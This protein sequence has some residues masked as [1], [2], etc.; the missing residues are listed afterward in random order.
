LGKRQN[1]VLF[2]SRS[3]QSTLVGVDQVNENLRQFWRLRRHAEDERP[4]VA[5]Q[6]VAESGIT[7]LDSNK[8][9]VGPNGTWYDER[10]RYMEWR[11]RSRSWNWAAALSFGGW[12][13][14]R[15]MY[16][17]AMLYLA[18]LGLLLGLAINGVALWLLAAALLV[19]ALAL[20]NYGNALYLACFRRAA[21]RAAQSEG[22]HEDRLA[23][24][25]RAGGTSRLA[26]GVMIAAGLG[27]A[28]AV[29]W[30]TYRMRDGIDLP[31]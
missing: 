21:L 26:V 25:A 15:K 5:D 28:G 9:F 8:T 19:A 2:A 13:A 7:P 4:T 16:A 11:G 12:L 6:Y 20:G 17:S 14:Y 1:L 23:A 3:E 10:W 24:L 27:L 18:W 22:Q 29:I 30:A 31:Y